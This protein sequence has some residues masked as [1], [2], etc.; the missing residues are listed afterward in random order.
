MRIFSALLLIIL[1]CSPLPLALSQS[2][3]SALKLDPATLIDDIRR[4]LEAEPKISSQQLA[5]YANELLIN[6]GFDFQ[7]DRSRGTAQ[8]TDHVAAPVVGAGKCWTL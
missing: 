8:G 6:K 4:K 3:H 1:L 7:F 5:Q 2:H